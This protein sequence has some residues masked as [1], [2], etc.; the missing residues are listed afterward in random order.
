M[1]KRRPDTTAER[2]PERCGKQEDPG[3]ERDQMANEAIE[4]VDAQPGLAL[5]TGSQVRRV[6]SEML[7]L[8]RK[9][10]PRREVAEE[11]LFLRPASRCLVLRKGT[12]VA[13]AE[14]LAHQHE[15][16]DACVVTARHGRQV[17]GLIQDA[18]SPKHLKGA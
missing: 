15:V 6:V 10:S 11:L 17:R 1:S 13:G 12:R 7:L 2:D 14:R 8:G 18:F 4:E 16:G 5:E 9:R 3:R